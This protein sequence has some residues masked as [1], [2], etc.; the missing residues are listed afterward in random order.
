MGGARPD[1]KDVKWCVELSGSVVVR[2][3]G[4]EMVSWESTLGI[5]R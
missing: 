4:E 1:A 5:R 2:K 3:A